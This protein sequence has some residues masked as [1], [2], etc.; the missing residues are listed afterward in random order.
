MADTRLDDSLKTS[1]TILTYN[2]KYDAV[3][4]EKSA[5]A[6]RR[7]DVNAIINFYSPDIFCVQE[8][9]A[10]QVADMAR[11]PA[12]SHVAYGRDDGGSEGEHV[13]IFYKT[14]RYTVTDQG[15][16]WLSPT[17]DIPSYGWNARH[18]RMAVWATLTD[19]HTNRTGAPA[20]TVVSAHLDHEYE[21]ARVEGSKVLL[22]R[23][24]QLSGAGPVIL[25]GDFNETPD[26]PAVQTVLTQFQDSRAISEK[27]PIGPNGTYNG[28]D[29]TNVNP[30]ARI[31]Y[32]FVKGGIK[33][34][35]QAN[36]LTLTPDGRLPS[37]HFPA[38]AE[39]VI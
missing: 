5:W 35:R 6:A 19:Q 15:V 4:D 2:V 22:D 28:F 38:L 3:R 12:Y 36:I 7:D 32:I 18:R 23:I 9:L 11:L 34:I 29:I 24:S 10:H 25:A 1:F 26:A 33:V 31:D 16:F 17:P 37:D 21:E 39:L 14:N 13:A 27:T 20:L 8:P 30:A